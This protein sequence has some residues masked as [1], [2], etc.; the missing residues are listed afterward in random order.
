MSN[1]FAIYSAAMAL[2]MLSSDLEPHFI[3][4]QLLAAAA[5]ELL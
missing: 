2:Y 3:V 4:N 5:T 1:R